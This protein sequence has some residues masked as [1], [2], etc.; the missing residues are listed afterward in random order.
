VILD[1]YQGFYG[2]EPL[3]PGD[4]ILSF[5]AKPSIQ[6]RGRI[7]ATLP[8]APGRPVRLEHEYVRHGAL[9]LLAGLDVH[10]GQMFASTRRPRSA[11]NGGYACAGASSAL[12]VS[13]RDAHR[14]LPECRHTVR[15]QDRHIAKSLTRGRHRAPSR[16][17]LNRVGANSVTNSG[18]RRF[19]T[20]AGRRGTYHH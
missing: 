1:L 16:L 3:G 10:T 9:A 18:G 19:P 20:K 12:T 6:A 13:A 17:T 5:D 4:W 14:A 15:P 2:G 11:R 7:H 8:A